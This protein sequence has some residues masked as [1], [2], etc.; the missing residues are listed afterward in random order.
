MKTRPREAR[1]RQHTECV[2]TIV[3]ELLGFKVCWKIYPTFALKGDV[4]LVKEQ[5]YS[6]F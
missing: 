5:T 2:Y 3:E 1:Q 4:I 6:L